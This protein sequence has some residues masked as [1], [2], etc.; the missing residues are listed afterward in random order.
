M[1]NKILIS[2]CAVLAICCIV[3][4]FCLASVKG[5]SESDNNTSK[6][7]FGKLTRNAIALFHNDV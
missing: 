3:L 1:K 5:E 7:K 4:S 2:L 6:A